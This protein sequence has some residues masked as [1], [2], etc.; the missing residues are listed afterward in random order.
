VCSTTSCERLEKE[1]EEVQASLEDALRRLEE[2]HQ[3]ELAQLEARLQAFYQAEWD[4]VHLTYQEQ[5]DK[6]RA[7]MEQ[8]VGVSRSR[9]LSLSL[10]SLLS[11]STLSAYHGALVTPKITH[12]H[13]LTQHPP[14]KISE[15]PED[16]SHEINSPCSCLRVSVILS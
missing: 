8:Q 10:L 7:L 5:A 15:P 12:T 4:K 16:S 13:T 9:S 1:K 14:L 2:Q 3:Q 11:L 6:C